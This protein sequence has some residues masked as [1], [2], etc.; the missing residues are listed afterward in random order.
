MPPV[1][2]PPLDAGQVVEMRMYAIWQGQEF[3]NKH[4]AYLTGDGGALEVTT[5]DVLLAFR[6]KARLAFKPVTPAEYFVREWWAGVIHSVVKITSPP[7][8][9]R[10]KVSYTDQTIALGTLANDTG[11][12]SETQWCP[13]Y[14]AVTM[15]RYGAVRNKNWRSTI[16]QGPVAESDQKNG[17]LED[18]SQT[19]YNNAYLN[20]KGDLWTVGSFDRL[21]TLCLFSPAL[22]VGKLPTGMIDAAQG[23]NDWLSSE[24]IGRQNTRKYRPAGY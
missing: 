22:A 24:T 19:I 4:Y 16:R 1:F 14:C 18:A 5:Q 11:T 6:T 21:A 20:V 13:P 17:Y 10:W 23:I 12:S 9:D 8:P 15:N 7:A 2:L 3:I